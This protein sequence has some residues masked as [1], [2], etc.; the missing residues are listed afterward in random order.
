LAA[1]QEAYEELASKV[2]YV[3]SLVAEVN[4]TADRLHVPIPQSLA[5]GMAA[6][7]VFPSEIRQ[8]GARRAGAWTDPPTTKHDEP[9]E[10]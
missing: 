2:E 1:T 5:R 9:E 3:N 10:P 6:L 7:L 4:A 8:I